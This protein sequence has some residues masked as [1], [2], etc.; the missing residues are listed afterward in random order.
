MALYAV[1]L[2]I[3]GN[4]PVSVS[5][6]GTSVKY[7]PAPVGTVPPSLSAVAGQN[8]IIV[9]PGN[10][11]ANGQLF[12]VR[13]CGNYTLSGDATSPLVVLGLYPVTFSSSTIPQPTI[14]TT[15]VV[16]QNITPGNQGS[17]YPWAFDVE[18]AGDSTSGLVQLLDGFIEVDGVAGTVTQGLVSG[19]TGI[20]FNNQFPFGFVVGI[21]WSVGGAGNAA[22]MYQFGI[23]N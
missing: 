23:V 19:L 2:A 4:F 20:N 15:A 11:Q 12:R 18:L 13:G 21:T 14:V 16:S 22:N 17:E 9:V 1:N 8:G 5:G 3:N 7:F 10:N 6:I